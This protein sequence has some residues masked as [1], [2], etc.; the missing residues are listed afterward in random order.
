MLASHWGKAS[1]GSLCN[2]EG[3]AL[4]NTSDV[5]DME[6]LSSVS[7][8]NSGQERNY[9]ADRNTVA[10]FFSSGERCF[11]HL[12]IRFQKPQYLAWQPWCCVFV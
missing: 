10:F 9:T 12:L 7:N 1:I 4:Q 3:Q 11:E 6:L 2:E 8:Q 5:Q